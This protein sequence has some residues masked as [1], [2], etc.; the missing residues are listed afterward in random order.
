[1]LLL[2]PGL[3]GPKTID[4]SN[5]HTIVANCNQTEN[6]NEKSNDKKLFLLCPC[7]SKWK[8]LSDIRNIA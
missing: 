2:E 7:A 4:V 6:W 3:L 8:A 5:F 1:M